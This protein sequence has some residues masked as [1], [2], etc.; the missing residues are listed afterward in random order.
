MEQTK[1]IIYRKIVSICI[2][3]CVVFILLF[4]S[5]CSSF[6]FAQFL[7]NTAKCSDNVIYVL[8]DKCTKDIIMQYYSKVK[9]KIE[10]KWEYPYEAAVDGTG[11]E[12]K[13]GLGISRSGAVYCVSVLDSSGVDVLD[14]AA[15]EAIFDASPFDSLPGCFDNNVYGIQ[16]NFKY[17]HM[18]KKKSE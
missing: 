16:S 11:G 2:R 3:S 14:K 13:I 18:G 9:E 6:K 17:V 8:P 12:L 4:A 10:S 7:R 15:L 5:S 1:D